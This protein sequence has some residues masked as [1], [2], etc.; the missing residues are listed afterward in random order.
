[1]PRLSFF[2]FLVFFFLL[3][4]PDGHAA[5]VE[6]RSDCQELSQALRIS[7]LD[8]GQG[9]AT[10]I[11]CAG[12]TKQLLIDA[13]EADE[14]YPN[15]EKKFLNAFLERMEGDRVLEY[16]I[17][18]HPHPDHL[19]GFSNLLD[20]VAKGSFRIEHYLDNGAEN[21]EIET[22]Q[23]I[24]RRFAA[25]NIPYTVLDQQKLEKIELCQGLDVSLLPLSPENAKQL[26]CP[27][28]FND[29]SIVTR[30]EV[31]GLRIL[32]LA[33]TTVY[34]QGAVIGTALIRELRDASIVRI[35]HH[36]N[37]AMT[38]EFVQ[39][40]RPSVLVLS[41]GEKFLGTTELRGY[42]GLRTVETLLEYFASLSWTEAL[43]KSSLSVCS[44]GMNTQRCSWQEKEVPLNLLSTALAGTIDMFITGAKVCVETEHLDKALLYTL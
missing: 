16:A 10:L 5:N 14:R 23:Q 35:G 44:N 34:W 37:K 41:N 12:S 26:G 15:A 13:G 6:L 20:K 17:L 24:R 42:P 18:T 2:P 9:D 27:A 19:S 11:R 25:L 30:I 8:V 29:C 31:E 3:L 22:D 33:D 21:S 39:L 1:M 28:N 38:P 36:G 40:L 7:F 4:C 43:P 32:Q